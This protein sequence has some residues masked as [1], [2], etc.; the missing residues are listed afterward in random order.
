MG[1]NNNKNINVIPCVHYSN[2]DINKNAI[3]EENRG[4][5]GIYR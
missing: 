5:S 3:Y 1:N 2:V 4:K